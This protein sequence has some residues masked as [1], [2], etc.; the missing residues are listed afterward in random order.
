MKIGIF[1]DTHLGF[2]EGSERFEDSF[3]ALSQALRIFV[4]KKVDFILLGGDVFDSVDPSNEVLCKT[5]SHLSFLKDKPCFVSVVIEKFGENVSSK[6][7]F[8]SLPIFAIHGNHEFLGKDRKSTLDVLSEANLIYYFHSSKLSISKGNEKV[9][10]FGLGAV[11]EKFALDVFS[12]WNPVPEKNCCNILLLHQGF[13][14]FMAVEDEMVATLSLENLPKGF[15]LVVNG[16][17]HWSNVQNL[18]SGKFLL[19]GSTIPTSIKSLEAKAS[20]GVFIFDTIS[21]SLDFVSFPKQRKV[22]YHKLVFSDADN[23]E[24]V[25]KCISTIEADLVEASDS[26]PLVRL[27]LKGTL[28]KGLS[29]ADINVS[30]VEA[31]FHNKVF[32]SLSKDFSSVSFLKKISEVRAEQKGKMSVVSTGFSILE[33]N[34]AETRFPSNID[35]KAFF[36]ALVDSD[37]DKAEKILVKKN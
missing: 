22:F 1:S 16:H 10:V 28:K 29:N 14:E 2:G 5:I 25:S 37:F 24:V 17:L 7:S 21:K 6:L 19:A 33:K 8:S 36:D 20:K 32:L 13:K 9:V 3:L 26:K 15:D 11:P 18:H 35:I 27:V 12:K 4:E 34:L 31:K 30:E 23:V